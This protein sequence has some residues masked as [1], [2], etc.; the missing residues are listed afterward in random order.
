MKS[1]GTKSVKDYYCVLCSVLRFTMHIQQKYVKYANVNL[2][3]RYKFFKLW[4]VDFF[5]S[6]AYGQKL[7]SG[8]N[9]TVTAEA[10]FLQ[11][12]KD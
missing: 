1:I 11:Y 7:I 12:V 9:S 2:T 6:V 4:V 5:F 10:W 8:V 3:G